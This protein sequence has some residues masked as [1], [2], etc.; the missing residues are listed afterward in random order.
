LKAV[1]IVAHLLSGDCYNSVACHCVM[2]RSYGEIS[3]SLCGGLTA[4]DG[5]MSSPTEDSFLQGLVTYNDLLQNP[6]LIDNPDLVVRLNGK[7]YSWRVACLLVMSLV[8]Y[9]TPLP[10]VP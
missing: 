6:K 2:C 7:Y 4:T 5:N 10:Q 1:V 3:L 9:Q 8:V